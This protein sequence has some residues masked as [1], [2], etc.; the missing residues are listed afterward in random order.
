MLGV[1][2][3][4]TAAQWQAY[5]TLPNDILTT[6]NRTNGY[7]NGS[8]NFGDSFAYSLAVFNYEGVSSTIIA[9]LVTA[10]NAIWAS[11]GNGHDFTADAAATCTPTSTS[12]SPAF[13]SCP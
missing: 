3:T 12:G 4:F 9:N 6:P 5:E 1:L 2:N 11:P 13:L 7:A 8:R 10:I